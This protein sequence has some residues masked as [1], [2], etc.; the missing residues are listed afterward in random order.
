MSRRNHCLDATTRELDRAGC[1]YKVRR[2]GGH[3]KVYVPALGQNII[4][5]GSPGDWRAPRNARSLVR[6]R[7]R[8]SGKLG[9]T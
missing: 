9:L 6:H 8:Q 4:I 7:L 1:Q 5:A 3:L 2:A